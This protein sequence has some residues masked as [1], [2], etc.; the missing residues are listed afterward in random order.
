MRVLRD[1]NVSKMVE[2]DEPLFH[3]L[4]DDLFPGITVGREEH[5]RLQSAVAKHAEAAR[6]INSPGWNLKLIQMFEQWRVR[7]GLCL[8]GPSGAGK[9]T[10]FD[11]LAKALSE[12]EV[13]IS[14]RKMNPKAITATQMFGRL[15]PATNDWTDGLHHRI[16]WTDI[17]FAMS[18]HSF[19]VCH[20]RCQFRYLVSATH[21]RSSIHLL[22]CCGA[23]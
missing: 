12:V 22:C 14:V 8:M 16:G 5:G 4:I 11:V 13:S 18:P 9:S 15:D 21:D 7:H 17:S 20:C 2:E 1:M 6:L 19:S 23:W 3:S 10:L